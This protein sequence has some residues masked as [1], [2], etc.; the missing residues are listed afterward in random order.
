MAFHGLENAAYTGIA[1]QIP[2]LK[3]HARA[4]CRSR[5]A[6]DDLVQ[7]CV[8]RA[9]AKAAHFHSD[10]E[11]RAWLFTILHNLCLAD[12]RFSQDPGSGPLEAA[13]ASSLPPSL[14]DHRL[15]LRALAKVA[16]TLP[17]HRHR[18]LAAIDGCGTGSE[19]QR[20]PAARSG[21]QAAGALPGIEQLH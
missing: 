19:Q 18:P 3:A 17:R 16:T 5:T 1:S 7:E 2:D 10:R 6:A 20:S 13:M 9:F 14:P 8:V 11:L 4:R 12:P 21:R 15:L